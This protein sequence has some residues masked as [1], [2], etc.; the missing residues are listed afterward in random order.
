MEFLEEDRNSHR[1]KNKDGDPVVYEALHILMWL[2]GYMVAEESPN[3][4]QK[5]DILEV[6][7][8]RVFYAHSLQTEKRNTQVSE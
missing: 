3:S 6:H 7:I 4:E 2:C 1:K 8:E 5:D